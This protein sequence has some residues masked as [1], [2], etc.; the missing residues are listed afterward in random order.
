MLDAG[1]NSC[2]SMVL[3]SGVFYDDFA[4]LH[5]FRPKVSVIGSREQMCINGDV[6]NQE[7]NSAKVL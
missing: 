3:V 4:L 2:I 6:L 1:H 5:A 7:N